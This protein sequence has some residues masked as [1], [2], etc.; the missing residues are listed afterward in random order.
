MPTKL[1]VR[2]THCGV[3]APAAVVDQLI[4]QFEEAGYAPGLAI[5]EQGWLMRTGGGA[6]GEHVY[7]CPADRVASGLVRPA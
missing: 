6:F 7:A 2:C 3:D 5:E 4:H 1:D